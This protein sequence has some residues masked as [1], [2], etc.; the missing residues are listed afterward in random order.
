MPKSPRVLAA[1]ETRQTSVLSHANPYL[2]LEPPLEPSNLVT[3]GFR[4]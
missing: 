1:K 4:V 2:S 3:E